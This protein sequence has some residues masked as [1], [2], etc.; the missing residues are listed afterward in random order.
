MI[1]QLKPPM[2]LLQLMLKVSHDSCVQSYNKPSVPQLLTGGP[3]VQVLLDTKFSLSCKPSRG[4][5]LITWQHNGQPLNCETEGGIST[6]QFTN[7]QQDTLLLN[8]VSYN[9]AGT[10]TCTLVL[11]GEPI[12]SEN[13]TLGIIQS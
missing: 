10:Y 4:S 7:N 8:R 1:I 11:N 6:C 2:T 5:F 3:V 12:V 13:I 9:D